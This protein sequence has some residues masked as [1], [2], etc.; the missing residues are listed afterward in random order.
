MGGLITTHGPEIGK[1]IHH[2]PLIPANILKKHHVHEPLDPRFRSA[3]RLLQGL[4]RENRDLAIGGLVS[5]C[6]G[7]SG[8]RRERVASRM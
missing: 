2:V 7:M 3:A 6:L 8:K 5:I 1:P 4:W